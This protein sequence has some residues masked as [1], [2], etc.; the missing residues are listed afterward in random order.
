MMSIRSRMLRKVEVH[1]G[2]TD[3]DKGTTPQW[4]GIEGLGST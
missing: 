1:F 3:H 4:Y 2:D